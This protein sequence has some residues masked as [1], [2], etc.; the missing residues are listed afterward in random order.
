MTVSNTGTDKGYSIKVSWIVGCIV[1]TLFP[2]VLSVILYIIAG[3]EL[4]NI[5]WNKIVPDYIICVFSISANVLIISYNVKEKSSDNNSYFFVAA[6]FMAFI[7]VAFYYFFY[8]SRENA[9][10]NSITTTII[11]IIITTVMLVVNT[12]IGTNITKWEN[13][14]E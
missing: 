8:P 13:D 14:C 1:I 6:L 11:L 5:N 4:K 12:I 9:V 2:L 7:C 3:Y 10:K